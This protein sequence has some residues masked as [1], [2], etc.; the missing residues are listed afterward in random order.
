MNSLLIF[1]MGLAVAGSVAILKMNMAV[2]SIVD[3]GNNY[4]THLS[5]WRVDGAA[6]GTR[7]GLSKKVAATGN[8]N[9]NNNNYAAFDIQQLAGDLV[10]SFSADDGIA[11]KDRTEF[12]V[13]FPKDS[14][15][16]SF[17]SCQCDIVTTDCLDV[18]ACMPGL[19][20]AQNEKALVWTGIELRRAMKAT[21]ELTGSPENNWDLPLGKGL[22]YNL[23]DTWRDWQEKNILPASYDPQGHSIF[24]HEGR[25]PDCLVETKL[26]NG[27]NTIR[28]MGHSCFYEGLA[29]PEDSAMIEDE[30]KRWF[31]TAIPNGT[32]TEEQV[33]KTLEDFFGDHQPGFEAQEAQQQEHYSSLGNLML[34]AHTTRMIF[35]RRPFLEKLY[36][37]KLKSVKMSDIHPTIRKENA[38]TDKNNNNNNTNPFNVAL[39]IRRG[40]SCGKHVEEKFIDYESEASPLDSIAQIGTKRMCYKTEVYLD[41]VKRIRA[42]VPERRPIHVYLATDDVGHL[43]DEIT[44]KH[45]SNTRDTYGID[46]LYFLDYSRKHF[47]YKTD[48]I[49]DEE[50]GE[51]Q[52]ILGETAVADLWLLS[53][54]HA[55]VGHKGSRFGKSSWL[56]AMARRNNFVPFFSVDGHSFCCEIDESCAAVKPYI[57]VENCLTFGHEYLRLDH[58]DYWTNGSV[59]RK[60]HFLERHNDQT[61]EEA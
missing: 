41:A 25:Y 14:E 35:N 34:F 44:H 30:A 18:I 54:G 53:H 31:E 20:D 37:E 39:H 10:E 19:H 50:N 22:Q 8:S 61:S 45:G 58:E 48:S 17:T 36:Q 59:V 51:Y 11:S 32:E 23:M 56:L 57:T 52:P 12:I 43:V 21:S 16:K 27:T 7:E 4:M 24:I 1:M 46:E 47:N 60:K 38:D 26:P 42:L 40:D 13:S 6:R 2:Q 9:N 3:E 28:F 49:E 29:G 15:S 33:R 5:E 55:F